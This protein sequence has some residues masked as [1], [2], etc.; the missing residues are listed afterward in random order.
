MPIAH[1]FP[2]GVPDVADSTLVRPSNWNAGH[3]VNVDLTTEVTGV[4]PIANGGST[5]TNTGDQTSI[6]G[7][8]G[9]KSQFNTACTDG[10]FLFVGDVIGLTDGDKGDITVSS[11]GTVWTIDNDVITYAKMQNIS[12]T[13]RLLGRD[14]TGAGDTEELTVSGGIEFT[15]LGGIQTSAFTGDATKTAGGT[16]LTLATVNANVGTFGSATQASVVTA[17]GKGLITA[18][19]NVTITPAVGSITGLGTGVATFLATPSSANLLA[20]VTDET[21]TGALVFGTAPVF[22][23]SITTPVIISASADPAD[24]GF[25]RMGNAELIAWEANAAGTDLT[26]TMDANNVLTASAPINATTGFRIGNA[27]A[28]GKFLVGNGTNYVAS[29]STIPTSAGATAN[30]VLLSDGTNYV[31]STPTFPNASATAGKVIRSDGTNYAASTF[32]IPDTYAQGDLLYG[33]ATNVLTALAKDANATRYLSNQGTSNNP[34]WNQVNLANGVTGT[35]PIANIAAGFVKADGTIALT[36]DWDAGSFEIRAQTLESDVAT[37]T[38]PLTIASTTLVTNLN[39]DLLDGKNTGTS[40]N[41]VPL[42]DGANTWSANQTYNDNIKNV[43][44]TGSDATIYYDATNLIIDPNEVG[45]GAVSMGATAT[46]TNA[47]GASQTGGTDNILLNKIGMGGS[48]IDSNYWLNY[49]LTTSV[50]RG[51]LSFVQV[52]T[53]SGAIQANIVSTATQQGSN[54]SPLNLNYLGESILDCN[55]SGTS[56]SGMRSIISIDGARAITQ[57]THT[58]AGLEIR[59]GEV[60]GTHTGGTITRYGILQNGFTALTVSGATSRDWGASFGNDLQLN[61]AGAG[62]YIKEGTNATMG[63]ST[64]VAGTVVVTNSKVTAN[65]RI[66]LTPQNASGTA[67]SVSISARTAGTSFTI[68]STNA[69]DTRLVAWMIM[70]PAP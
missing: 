2:S 6:V 7:I 53:G 64:L 63:A 14:T 49:T 62:F 45:T 41:V 55:N 15:G 25:I 29:T 32:T 20:A 31:L 24:A 44:G 61:T 52:Y 11:S 28:T 33:S 47:L 21:G 69:L 4:L 38:A 39:A 35:L 22:T 60:G 57:G 1:A 13:D 51:A 54:A 5:G 10:D 68:L 42:L 40:G 23:T 59:N 16:A 3:V 58:Q 18:I 66:F 17:T 43:F 26:L 70:E 37:G 9:T 30:K 19:S 67:G 56:T 34:S 36:A 27:A 50:G 8:T 65:S 12:A 46:T 48:P